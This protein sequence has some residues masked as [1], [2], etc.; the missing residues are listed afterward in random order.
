MTGDGEDPGPIQLGSVEVRDAPER[1]DAPY[2]DYIRG[3]SCC[4]SLCG[5]P[6]SG[7]IEPHH[8]P[9]KGSGR[10]DD[11]KTAALCTVHHA[12]CHGRARIGKWSAATTLAELRLAMID[13]LCGY[14][15]GRG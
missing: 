15:D 6:C 2:L 1:W 8:S 4:A 13:A 10:A 9:T 11:R 7:V 3:L 14:L 5:T 12:D